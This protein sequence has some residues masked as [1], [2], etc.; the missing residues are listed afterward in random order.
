VSKY[1]FGL[2]PSCH[3]KLLEMSERIDARRG[4]VGIVEQIVL[5]SKR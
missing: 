5:A 3:P 1:P 2:R 4:H